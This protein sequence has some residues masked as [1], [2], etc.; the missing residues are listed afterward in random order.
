MGVI[1]Y[2]IEFS[3]IWQRKRLRNPQSLEVNNV[4]M[5]ASFYTL[6]TSNGL[7]RWINALNS[8]QCILKSIIIQANSNADKAHVIAL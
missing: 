5:T 4:V 8:N 6:K 3:Q 2:E 7:R 1:V